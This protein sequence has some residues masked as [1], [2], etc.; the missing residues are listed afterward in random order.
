MES[1]HLQNGG[2]R[3]SSKKKLSKKQLSALA[4]GRAIRAK[5]IRKNRSSKKKSAKKTK[6]Q[7]GGAGHKTRSVQK[8]AKVNWSKLRAASSANSFIKFTKQQVQNKL[9]KIAKDNKLNITAR[10][11]NDVLNVDLDKQSYMIGIMEY[12]AHIAAYIKQK[13]PGVD[14]QNIY[15]R[16]VTETASKISDKKYDILDVSLILHD[17]IKNVLNTQVG[18]EHHTDYD[19]NIEDD[20]GAEF[21]EEHPMIGSAFLLA[22]AAAYGSV[23]YAVGYSLSGPVLG[24]IG[25][26]ASTVKLMGPKAGN[27]VSSVRQGFINN[28]ELDREIVDTYPDDEDDYYYNNQ[29]E[30]D[31]SPEEES[32]RNIAAYKQHMSK[33]RLQRQNSEQFDVN[34]Q[35]KKKAHIDNLLRERGY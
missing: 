8:K 21:F 9:S 26:L 5:N 15:D 24:A 20:R 28:R 33:M 16:I 14:T 18:G 22:S 35:L 2:K 13:S 11:L 1:L 23:G 27:L 12:A 4:R 30:P 31:L 7:K 29:S 19:R 34:Y 25:A 3:R 6:N 10:V 32:A 17:V